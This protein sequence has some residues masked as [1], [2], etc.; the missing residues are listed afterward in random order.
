MTRIRGAPE[1]LR[2]LILAESF[3]PA[4]V[5]A[6]A[7][8]RTWA[9]GGRLFQKY[10]LQTGL[11]GLSEALEQE[12]DYLSQDRLRDTSLD[13][14]C[15]LFVDK[16]T[17]STPQIDEASIYFDIGD[18]KVAGNMRIENG[19]DGDSGSGDQRGTRVIV[20]VPFTGSPEL[21]NCQPS[22]AIDVIPPRAVVTRTELAFEYGALHVEGDWPRQE[23]HG[24][25]NGLKTYLAG[26]EKEL[27]DY[28]AS[29]RE[30]ARQ[31]VSERHT[32]VH[33]DGSIAESLGFPIRRA[34]DVA[35]ARPQSEVEPDVAP[36]P[37]S[38]FPAI[39]HSPDYKTLIVDGQKLRMRPM[40]VRTIHFIYTEWM[41]TGNPDVD[42]ETVLKNIPTQQDSLYKAVRHGR[43]RIWNKMIRRGNTKGT[44]R[45]I[46]SAFPKNA[47][48][49]AKAR[50]KTRKNA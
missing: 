27:D 41:R 29:V 30:I 44:V 28:N 33:Q 10:P 22:M 20:H 2:L 50:Q 25:L 7:N 14:L 43:R 16:F 8:S 23:F 21:F 13:H 19:L 47:Q 18:A 48:K 37:P 34:M 9:G 26:I 5:G 40:A 24:H 11:E 17:L 35:D 1:R 39:E 4:L 49:R 42:E 31:R 12:I 3:G 36:Q 38:D 6:T 45:L 15:D 32:I 46:L